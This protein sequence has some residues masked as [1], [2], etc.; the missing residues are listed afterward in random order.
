MPQTPAAKPCAGSAYGCGS[1]AAPD[2][3]LCGPCRAYYSNFVW[4]LCMATPLSGW[5]PQYTDRELRDW[6]QRYGLARLWGQY[7][8]WRSDGGL[9]NLLGRNRARLVGEKAKET[10]YA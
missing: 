8:A 1:D 4:R 3:R 10:T 2:Q 7:V 6:A 9:D 5:R